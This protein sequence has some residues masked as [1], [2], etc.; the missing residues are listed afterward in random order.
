MP[1]TSLLVVCL[2]AQFASPSPAQEEAI[3]AYRRGVACVE[4]GEHDSALAHFNK[5]LR[6]D[7]KLARAYTARGQIHLK[8]RAY[9]KAVSDFTA[10]I[11]LNQ[12]GYAAYIFQGVAYLEKGDRERMIADHQM[13]IELLGQT[14]KVSEPRLG[15]LRKP[16]RINGQELKLKQLL[17]GSRSAYPLRPEAFDRGMLDLWEHKLRWQRF[18][19]DRQWPTIRQTLPQQYPGQRLR[20]LLIDT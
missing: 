10:A 12:K 9:D 20:L 18:Q 11:R 17:Q 19:F 16:L 7:P 15:P 1:A 5:A 13:A 3:D 8:T 14:L 2:L 4:R 6:L